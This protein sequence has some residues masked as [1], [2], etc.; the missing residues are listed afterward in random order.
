MKLC[1]EIYLKKIIQLNLLHQRLMKKFRKI[2]VKNLEIADIEEEMDEMIEEMIVLRV[3]LANGSMINI[4]IKSME[5]VRLIIE[6]G[7]LINKFELL[8]IYPL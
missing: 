2:H 8:Y 6:E 4:M 1:S 7:K 3:D 5:D